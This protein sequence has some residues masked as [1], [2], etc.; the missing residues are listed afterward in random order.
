[1]HLSFLSVMTASLGTTGTSDNKRKRSNVCDRRL[2]NVALDILKKGV[3]SPSQ[4]DSFLRIPCVS[5]SASPLP[6]LD[7][8]TICSDWDD[9]SSL[10][11]LSLADERGSRE[12]GR[13]S[14]FNRYW[15]TKGGTPLLRREPLSLSLYESTEDSAE[16]T[17]ERSLG[18]QEGDS[19]T[20]SC[21]ASDNSRRRI[22]FGNNT[23]WSQSLPALT[24][25]SDSAERNLRVTQSSSVL[26]S[27]KPKQSCLRQ[28]RYSG[29][30][31][32]LLDDSESSSRTSVR[33]SPKADVKVFTPP[34]EIWA[35]GGWSD[36]FA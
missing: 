33:F 20:R 23:C 17:Y 19:Q 2:V 7:P 24:S 6:P 10:S 34:V 27:R 13:R 18:Y 21:P 14:I 36:W 1:V 30:Q 15:Q 8:V 12:K 16:K 9:E 35:P 11:S 26:Q 31:R 28:G 5:P 32:L 4:L 29:D 22:I 25:L 3:D